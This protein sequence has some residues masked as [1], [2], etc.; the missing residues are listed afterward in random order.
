MNYFD[1]VIVANGTFPT[2]PVPLAVLQ[3]ARHIVACD[4]A[5]AQLAAHVQGDL[6]SPTLHLTIVGDGDSVPAEYRHLL[7]K[8]EEQED[9][10]LTKATRYCLGNYPKTNTQ[11][12][13]LRI[14]YLG[15]T[16]A[17]ED[18]TLGNISLLMRYYR[19]MGVE[20]CMFTDNGFF[21][22][23]RGNRTFNSFPGQQVSIFNFGCT[24]LTS[25]GL[26]WDSYAYREWWQGTLNEAVGNSLTL[27]A[28][29]YYLVFQTYEK[30]R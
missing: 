21:T 22:P 19:E 4:G 26:K 13:A 7:I 15:C 16:G 29:S 18:H 12:P 10:D 6:Q 8:V 30:I 9:N 17:R 23:A 5:I 25:E 24:Q 11:H 2:H 3:G 20:G 14:A 27:Y 1:I 28:D